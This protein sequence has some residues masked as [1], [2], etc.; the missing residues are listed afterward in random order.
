MKI[1]LFCMLSYY[2]MYL[3]I[4]KKNFVFLL[5]FRRRVLL[6]KDRCDG[7]REAGKARC[8]N[9][10]PHFSVS[11]FLGCIVL[12]LG[13]VVREDL[14]EAKTSPSSLLSLS[15]LFGLFLRLKVPQHS[16]ACV[17]HRKVGGRHLSESR[18]GKRRKIT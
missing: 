8:E 5:L 3:F 9:K 17:E 14:K 6:P 12:F 15:D 1:C 2:F 10:M 18:G 4:Y 7:G 16:L 11:L 13:L